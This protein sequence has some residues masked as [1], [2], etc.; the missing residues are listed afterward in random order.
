[1]LKLGIQASSRDW[2]DENHVRVRVSLSPPVGL[3][4][5]AMKTVNTCGSSSGFRTGGIAGPNRGSIPLP[6]ASY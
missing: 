4:G 6:Q 3:S 1:M 2:C 5:T